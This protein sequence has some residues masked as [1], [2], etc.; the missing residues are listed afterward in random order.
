ME[1]YLDRIRNKKE[2]YDLDKIQDALAAGETL[3][4]HLDKV[5]KRENHVNIDT[6]F[7]II[8]DLASAVN[9]IHQAGAIHLDIKPANIILCD[10]RPILMN[11]GVLSSKD[12]P[13]QTTRGEFVGTIRY[14]APEYLFG[15]GYDSSIDIREAFPL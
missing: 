9:V 12:F 15:E 4:G 14:A 13:E 2:P 7:K 3:E 8:G 1:T 5:W 11:F 10:D 6:T